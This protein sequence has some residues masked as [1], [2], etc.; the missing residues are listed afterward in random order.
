M[1]PV[2]R[3]IVL[4]LCACMLAATMAGTQLAAEE[5]GALLVFFSPRGPEDIFWEQ[6]TS[7]MKE[8]V[9]D[10][11]MRL[12]V[13]H[14][15]GSHTKMIE[16]A[17]QSLRMDRPSVLVFQNFKKQ[18]K[19]LL[20][21]AEN[22]RVPA[23]IVNAGFSTDENAGRPREKYRYWIGEMVPDDE[24]AG[25]L[26]ADIL[27]KNARPV[28]GGK[29]PVVALSGNIADNASNERNHGLQ[30]AVRRYPAAELRQVFTTDWSAEMARTKFELIKKSRYPETR[31]VWAA[32]DAIALGVIDGAKRMGLVMGRDIITGGIDWS[33]K[34]LKSVMAGDM[35]VTLGGHF[36]EGA[37][38]AVLMYDYLH[39]RDFAS[40]SV[41]MR[42]RMSAITRDN[43]ALHVQKLSRVNWG[44]IDFRRFSKTLNPD[45]LRYNF[46]LPAI[47]DQL[48]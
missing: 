33:E 45:L 16:Q 3:P 31:V 38:V 48:K 9:R 39:G 23:F 14:A 1:T 47:L 30:R 20:T 10:L 34:G 46:G 35:T 28:K 2:M 36:M 6:F 44:R 11:G 27:I 13:Y 8:A 21:L 5:S 22:K 41:R 12:K 43:A 32:G 19:P 17:E 7:F 25:F 4:L 24:E 15:Y 40:E 37:W 29:I 26:L 18:G 42:S